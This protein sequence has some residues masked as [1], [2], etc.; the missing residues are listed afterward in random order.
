MQ[1]TLA[2]GRKQRSGVPN[3]WRH[4]QRVLHAPGPQDEHN[5]AATAPGRWATGKATFCQREGIQQWRWLWR[6][7][8]GEIRGFSGWGWGGRKGESGSN[9]SGNLP[10]SFPSFSNPPFPLLRHAPPNSDMQ[11]GKAELPQTQQVKRKC[12]LPFNSAPLFSSSPWDKQHT[13]TYAHITTTTTHILP[14]AHTHTL[15]L[16]LHTSYPIL[17]LGP[18]PSR[19]DCGFVPAI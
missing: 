8:V 5:K 16:L 15:L 18:S 2:E 19:W 12:S 14:G 7:R 4:K 1:D 17:L 11:S 10:D 9:G 13:R 6:D 3:S